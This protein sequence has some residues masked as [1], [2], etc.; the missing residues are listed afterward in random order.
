V[1]G[2]GLAFETWATHSIFGRRRIERE[3]YNSTYR[4]R[5]TLVSVDGGMPNARTKH[6]QKSLRQF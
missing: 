6:L 4:L 3:A 2:P 1:G 5:L